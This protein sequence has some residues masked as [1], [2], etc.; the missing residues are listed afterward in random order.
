MKNT[1]Q[2]VATFAEAFFQV[3]LITSAVEQ[4]QI[5]RPILLCWTAMSEILID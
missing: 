5:Y 3:L 2:F 4:K 1:E